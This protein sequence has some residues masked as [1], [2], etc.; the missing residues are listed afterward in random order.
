MISAGID[1]KNNNIQLKIKPE[2]ANEWG[3]L[4]DDTYSQL[5]ESIILSGQ[6]NPIIVDR[7]GNIV[8]GQNRYKILQEL[9]IRPDFEVREFTDELSARDFGI[10][11]NLY[12]KESMK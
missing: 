8:D 5:K 1:K 3:I 10:T 9:G 11:S 2:Y 6:K 4:S 12:V 7:D